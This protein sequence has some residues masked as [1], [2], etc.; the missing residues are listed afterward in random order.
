MGAA[1]WDTRV[2]EVGPGIAARR[3]Y[4]D[5]ANGPTHQ[6]R[7]IEA[8]HAAGMLP[9]ISYKCGGDIAGAINGAYNSVADAAAVRLASYGRPTAVSFWH[10]PNGDLTPEQHV[11]AQKQI[12]P[13]FK[14]GFLKV[15]PIH[16]GF[17]LDN[18]VSKFAAYT[19]DEMFAIWD[20]VAVDTYEGGTAAAP[21]ARKPADRMYALSTYLKNRGYANMPIGVGE[22][23]GYSAATIAAAG[24]ALLSLPNVWFGCIW[25]SAASTD[26]VLTGDR[27]TA[28]Q[29]TL[30]D[31]RSA[32]PR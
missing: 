24:E 12:L 1:L 16:N 13:F 14:R 9:V 23:S 31:P 22:Y 4:A 17:L 28:F 21:G 2:A 19:P 5:L 30:A 26:W 3:I 29:R 27:L 10:E 11:A 18:Q 25:N 8:A 15:G 20:Y 7:A 32:D 6:I